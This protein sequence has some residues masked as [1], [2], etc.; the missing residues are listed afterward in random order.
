MSLLPIDEI[1]ALLA[2]AQRT[3]SIDLLAP[4]VIAIVEEC[5]EA[6]YNGAYLKGING[7]LDVELDEAT[8]TAAIYAVV[9]GENF[10]DRIER[11][12]TEGLDGF[13]TKVAVLLTTDGHRV[14]SEGALAAGDDLQRVGLTVT[15]TWRGVM[16]QR[17]RDAHIALEGV[18]I[19]YDEMFE[20]DGYKAPAPGLFEVAELDVNCRCE[21]EIHVIE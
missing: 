7:W 14:R 3:N 13:V 19:P 2:E 20:L 11:Y 5:L 6:E 16:D 15:K 18:T 10:A 9:G 4:A 21:L 17:E 12:V 1:N 8:R